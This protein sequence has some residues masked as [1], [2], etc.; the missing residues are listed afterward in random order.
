MEKCIS[1]HKAGVK[2]VFVNLLYEL[3]CTPLTAFWLTFY[4]PD[5]HGQN[6]STL[7]STVFTNLI[8]NKIMKLIIYY[9]V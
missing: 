1:N 6:L 3:D 9:L 4:H 7:F 8:W 2:V 5:G